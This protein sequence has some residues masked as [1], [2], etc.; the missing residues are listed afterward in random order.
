MRGKTVVVLAIAFAFI[1]GTMV[2][3]AE[4]VFAKEKL[5]KL[6]KEC[7]KEPK[8]ENKI[9]PHCELLNFIFGLQTQVDDLEERVTALENNIPPPP[10][11]P[12]QPQLLALVDGQ[13]VG[14]FGG[15]QVVGV[16]IKD[17][18]IDDTDEAKGEPFVTVNGDTLRMVQGVDGNWYAFFADRLN[19]LIADSGVAVPGTGF[20]FG[21]FCSQT[22]GFVLGPTIDV[23]ETQ[24]FAIQDPA[25]VTN[26]VDGNPAGTPLTNLCT[27]PNP[28]STPNDFM[29]VLNGVVDIPSIP[30]VDLAGQIGIRQGFWP[31]IQLFSFNAGDEVKIIYFKGGMEIAFSLTFE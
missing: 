10:P 5:T 16:V 22:S 29:A 2:A 21:V 14:S 1:L 27:D 17:P 3:G 23:T 28:T 20:D 26:G 11:L 6:L 15:P 31:F 12:P 9:K 24:G 19:A 4:D 8:K 7:K 18:D 25:L 30:S 13:V